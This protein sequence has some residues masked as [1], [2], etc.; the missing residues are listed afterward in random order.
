MVA[1]SISVAAGTSA[2]LLAT[3]LFLLR[4]EFNGRRPFVALT[5]RWIATSARTSGLTFALLAVIIVASIASIPDGAPDHR[6]GQSAA[7]ASFDTGDATTDQALTD[8]RAYADNIDI[9]SGASA[10][11]PSSVNPSQLPDV[12]TMIGKLVA[13]L[14][15]QPDDVKGWKMLGW[16]Y[17]NTGMPKEAAKAYETA[18]KLDPDD[19]EVKK[20]L[21][22]ANSPETGSTA[23][24][25]PG[26]ALQG[27]GTSDAA[28]NVSQAPANN[29]MVRGMVDQLA[30][31]L[32][33]S[34]NDE[35]G[36]QLLMRSWMMLG[37][38][39]A[40]KSALAKAIATFSH[41]AQAKTRLNAE[42][43]E[44]GVVSE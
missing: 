18:L 20:A 11:A 43:R 37:E 3:F 26:P 16:S 32:E 40:A 10:M 30:A 4:T 2:T 22:R 33:A 15:K 28:S 35:A 44:L 41:D 29:G 34:P 31:R 27:A 12:N 36:W 23:S 42:A 5:R 7:T 9:Q 21:D 17:L 39:D 13:R 24:F 1:L 8:L 38:N 14:E 19:I 25:A 6:N